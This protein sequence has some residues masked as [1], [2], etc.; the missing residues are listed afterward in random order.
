MEGGTSPCTKDTVSKG[1][2]AYVTQDL[3]GFSK[4]DTL[5]VDASRHAISSGETAAK[6]LRTL[7][8]K[9]VHIYHCAGLHAKV[10]LLDDV[11]VISSGKWNPAARR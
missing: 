2:H 3:V 6:L 4:G 9:G 10:L 7:K 5:V 11:A 1:G 8:M